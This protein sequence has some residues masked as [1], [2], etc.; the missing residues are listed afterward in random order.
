MRRNDLIFAKSLIA[1]V[2]PLK[3]LNEDASSRVFTSNRECYVAAM[4]QIESLSARGYYD[5]K[6]IINRLYKLRGKTSHSVYM[7][8]FKPLGID[9]NVVIG[10]ID[11]ERKEFFRKFIRAMHSYCETSFDTYQFDQAYVEF[12]SYIEGKPVIK[13]TKE[14]Q[15]EKERKN[16]K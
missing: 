3:L 4:K 8:Y 2:N 1:M 15:D 10:R 11:R 7:C 9:P 12:V 16:Q 5:I 13:S 14:I 6:Y